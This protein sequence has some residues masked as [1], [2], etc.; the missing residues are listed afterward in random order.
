MVAGVY[1]HS[2]R[3]SINRGMNLVMFLPV[4]SR[5]I[6]QSMHL[7]YVL[8]LNILIIS[9]ICAILNFSVSYL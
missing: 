5:P 8:S 6:D 2:P 4:T 1:D 3:L 9:K 7:Q